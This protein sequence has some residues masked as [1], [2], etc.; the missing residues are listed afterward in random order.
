M[1]GV[2]FDLSGN[3]A[4]FKKVDANSS[5]LT[6]MVPPRTTVMGI[7][8]A[9][10]GEERDAY[11]QKYDSEHLHLGV[12][13]LTPLSTC[14]HT[15]N[16]VKVT[17]IQEFSSFKDHTQVPVEMVKGEDKVSY[18][19]YAYFEEEAQNQILKE[20]LRKH[21]FVYPPSLG[22]VFLQANIDYGIT[23]RFTPC[24]EAKRT[25]VW[26]VVPCSLVKNLELSAI[27]ERGLV[28]VS[29]PKDLNGDRSLKHISEYF[30][31]TQDVGLV[32][33]P[34]GTFYEVYSE[35]EQDKVIGFM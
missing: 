6:Y 24:K 30:F 31:T 27:P 18:R 2:S 35:R 26:G 17:K 15:V 21:H 9:M 20:R 11:Y 16:Y 32:V 33:E 10:M 1:E 4:H 14:F 5:S 19:I 34:K 28:K 22:P 29:M 7:I 13:I 12:R 8:A 23:C 25:K 3:F